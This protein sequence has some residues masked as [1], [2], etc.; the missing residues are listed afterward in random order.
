MAKFSPK[1]AALF[2]DA[3]RR[4]KKEFAGKPWREAAVFEKAYQIMLYQEMLEQG[5]DMRMVPT[6]GEYIEVDT[7]QD[8]DYARRIWKA[9]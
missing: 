9:S 2:R 5:V 3:Y 1:G 8:F 6:H 4:A 7:Q